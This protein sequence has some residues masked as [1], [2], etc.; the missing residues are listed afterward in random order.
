M[1]TS[2]RLK[3]CLIII[4]ALTFAAQ[5]AFA[6]TQ[7]EIQQ[8]PLFT[9]AQ[10]RAWNQF[11]L[12]VTFTHQQTGTQ[13]TVDGYADGD[14]SGGDNSSNNTLWNV[15]VALPLAGTWDWSSSS[16][17]GD[18]GLINKVGSITV[19]TPTPSQVKEGTHK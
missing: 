3:Y 15:R 18:S 16:S 11:P 13:F 9:S 5:D 10:G 6:V 17:T 14:N 4:A 2:H 7:W 8:L 1:H 12:Q 19:T